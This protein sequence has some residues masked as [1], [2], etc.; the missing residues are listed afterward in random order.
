MSEGAGYVLGV[1]DG[2][3]NNEMV[4]LDAHNKQEE[5][6]RDDGVLNVQQP[7]PLGQRSAEVP[8]VVTEAIK[9]FKRTKIPENHIQ[10]AVASSKNS[11]KSPIYSWGVRFEYD[12][13]LLSREQLEKYAGSSAGRPHLWACLA[14]ENCRTKAIRSQK[15]YSI[16]SGSSTGASKHLRDVHGIS[17][18]TAGQVVRTR[19]VG[20]NDHVETFWHNTK[21]DK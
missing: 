4:V 21:I 11:N 3:H 13:Q 15:T 18:G 6:H 19:Q 2:A 20:L 14:S 1:L 17:S 12:P 10:C 9:D 16:T 7:A 5:E 8:T